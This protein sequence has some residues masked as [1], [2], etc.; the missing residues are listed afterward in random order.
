ML[1]PQRSLVEM[2][3]EGGDWEEGLTP[4]HGSWWQ[5]KKL[6]EGCNC[7][8]VRKECEKGRKAKSQGGKWGFVTVAKYQCSQIRRIDHLLSRA[9]AQQCSGE[10]HRALGRHSN[11]VSISV[12]SM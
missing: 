12:P 7:L 10:R 9:K 3:W 6:P 4:G 8:R 11:P 2:C 5:Q 1:I